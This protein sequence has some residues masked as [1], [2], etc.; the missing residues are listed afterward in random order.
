MFTSPWGTFTYKV[1]PFGLCNAPTTFQRAIIGI[2]SDMVNDCMEIFMDEFTPYRTDFDEALANLEKVLKRGIQSHLSL[3]IE[4]CHMMMR[5]GVVLG[6][7]ISYAGIQVDPTKIQVILNIPTPSTPKEVRSILGYVGYYRRFIKKNSKLSS[8]LFF[9]LKKDVDLSWTDNCELSFSDMKHKLSTT[10][11]L[12][13]SNWALPFHISLDA[14]D[15]T[16][17]AVIGKQ[18]DKYPYAIYYISKNMA[19]AELNYTVT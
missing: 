13:G 9:L 11:I 4:K 10:P 17:G 6:H 12:R 19:P 16:I 8:P 18:E 1:L 7:Y 2:F 3:S 15:T 5:K 14:S